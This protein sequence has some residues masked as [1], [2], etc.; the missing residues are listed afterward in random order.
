MN[1]DTVYMF[2][3]LLFFKIS[4]GSTP[5]MAKNQFIVVK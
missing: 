3:L 2:N 4:K 5:A 1:M